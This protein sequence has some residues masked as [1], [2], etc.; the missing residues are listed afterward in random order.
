M[1]NIFKRRSKFQRNDEIDKSLVQKE[2]DEPDTNFSIVKQNEEKLLY[3]LK[4]KVEDSTNQTQNLINAIDSISNRVEEQIK[5]IYLVVDEIT[6]YSAMAEELHASSSDSYMKASETLDI[7][8]DGSGAVY[9]TIES[10][11]EINKSMSS[12]IEEINSLKTSIIQIEDILNI[13]R[14]IAKQTNLLALNAAIEAA[15]A[16]DAGRGFAVV[17]DE[18]KKLADKSTQSAD[19]ISNII[20]E[21]DI[22]VNNTINAIENSNNKVNEGSSIA[23]ESSKAF[24]SIEIAIKDMIQIM[25][26]ITEAVSIQ[27]SS[28]ESI[29]LSTNEM[30]ISSEKAMSMVESAMMNTQFTKATLDELNQVTKLLNAMSR[31][32]L[33][34]KT[35]EAEKELISIKLNLSE[36]IHTLDPAMSNIMENTRFLNNIHTGL[37]TTNDVGDVLP[38]IAKNWYVEDDNLTWIFNLRND[39]IFHNGKKVTAY[40]VKYSLE[41]LLSPELNSPNAWFIDY[42]EGAKEFMEGKEREVRGIKVLNDFRLSIKLEAAFS[43]FVLLLS[44]GCCA[45]MDSEELKKGN[46]VGCGPYILDSY[47]DN[48]YTLVANRN[49]IGG[50]PYCDIIEVLNGDTNALKNFLDGKYDFYIIQNKVEYETIRAGVLSKNIKLTDLLATFFIGFKMKN[51]SSQYTQKRVRQ[52]INYAINKKRIID[53]MVGG[54]ALEAKAMIPP[55]LVSCDH[56]EAYKYNPDKARDIIRKEGI[57]LSR[58][59]VILTGPY[60]HPILK[61]VEEDLKDIGIICRYEKISNEQFVKSKELQQG[62]DMYFYG[63]YADALDPSSF[64]KPLFAGNSESNLSGYEN[65]EVMEL[66][67]KATKM[68]NPKKRKQIYEE[69]Q[70]IIFEDMPCIP[71][72]HPQNAVCT[73]EMVYNVN[74]SPL[75]MLKYDNIIKEKQ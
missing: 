6:H 31:K 15:R 40:D 38:S 49:Y 64:I 12:V 27:T 53:E 42:I 66:I 58:P 72:F 21:I 75:A 2:K 48:M 69:I 17:A 9:N 41:R 63:W 47:K 67:E 55:K 28:L 24:K 5:Y 7:V 33:D 56:I 30:Q 65:Q 57:D 13:I 3:N 73:Q 34:E 51:T 8:E 36:P 62:Y 32:L 4:V 19:H 37:L 20:K 54:L 45:V 18:V 43:G 35:I 70:R 44:H 50:K 25:N 59:L 71:L 39:A 60:I 23:D 29:V 52:A 16:G 11:N 26:E 74:L 46:F 61:L 10:M 22:N 68:S 1:L 14:D